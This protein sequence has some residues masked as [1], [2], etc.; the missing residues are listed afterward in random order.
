MSIF[1]VSTYSIVQTC[2]LFCGCIGSLLPMVKQVTL[3]H[4]KSTQ[5]NLIFLSQWNFDPLFITTS[6]F[7][8]A[9]RLQHILYD[10]SFVL[11][12]AQMKQ[13]LLQ[14]HL[15]L[16]ENILKWMKNGWNVHLLQNFRKKAV[17]PYLSPKKRGRYKAIDTVF[18]GLV[19]K[20][21]AV[22]MQVEVCNA[23]RMMN[24]LGQC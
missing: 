5:D 11:Q 7:T 18:M 20:T 22:A 2:P 3:T 9:I 10:F 17:H 24:W 12:V 19:F 6:L 1:F 15:D 21:W 8:S 23:M 13:I 16:D 4:P 14:L